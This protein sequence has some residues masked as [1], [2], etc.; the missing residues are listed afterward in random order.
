MTTPDI[1]VLTVAQM[2]AAEQ[3][4]IDGGET[5]ESLMERAGKGVADW[6]YRIAA[7]RPVTVLCGPGNNGG[8]GYVIARE[9][10][11]R[12][13][14]VTVVAPMEPGTAAAKAARASWGGEVEAEGR[15]GV[16][17]DALFGS[18]LTR[19][20]SGP[21]FAQLRAEAAR[22]ALCVA[23]DVPSGID[24]DTGAAL[25]DGLPRYDLT[26]ALGAWKPAHALMPAMD[27]IGEI[28]LVPIGVEPV[29]GAAQMVGRPSLPA[30]GRTDHKYTRGLV[31]VVEGPMSGAAQ[32]VCQGAMHAGAGAVRLSTERSHP[33]LPPDVVLRSETLAE[34]L[35][36]RRTGAVVVGPGLGRDD[37]ARARLETVLAARRPSVIDADALALL[38][39][40]RLSGFDA[41]LVL[42]PHAGEMASLARSFGLAEQAKVEQA[43][44]LA[45]SARAVVI[46]KGPDSVIAAPDG[47][48]GFLRSAT[49][50]LSV[51]G[52]GDVLSGIV[53]SRLAATRDPWRAACE[54]AWLHVE[55]GRLAGPAF[56]ASEL[57]QRVSEAYAAAL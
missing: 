20:L 21:L 57:A 8:D 38:T 25:N 29:A 48:V 42:T 7:G 56:V 2:R 32:L 43:L 4:L 6:V 13:L 41:P 22:H 35:E 53:A 5:V 36:D 45:R 39:P 54:G 50:W 28:R 47:R 17:V 37:K 51:G 52:S 18:G 14:E 44:S 40:E 46:S 23:V 11:R 34:L 16:L 26:V 30:P 10:G 19:P 33:S 9:L 3:A 27:L 12:G 15:G 55:A 1:Q 24:S 49:S 31:L